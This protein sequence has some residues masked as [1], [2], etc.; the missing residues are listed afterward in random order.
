M[1]REHFEENYRKSILDS[2]TALEVCFS[3][4]IT[5]LL[6]SDEDL[7]KYVSSKHN[8]LRLKRELL[9]V[10]KVSLPVKEKEFTDGL[11]QVRNRVI[12]G[13]HNPTGKEASTAYKIAEETL[14]SV[15][16]KRY[17]M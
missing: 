15:L 1:Q 6:P 3:Y 5:Q 14:Y 16:R 7:N 12:H 10:L 2:A 9:K 8:S 11:D 17:E 13:G 4:L